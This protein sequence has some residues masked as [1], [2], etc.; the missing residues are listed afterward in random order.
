MGFTVFPEC[1]TSIVVFMKVID[2]YKI[3]VTLN[4]KCDDLGLVQKN[5]PVLVF[6]AE[7]DSG[8]LI[9][10]LVRNFQR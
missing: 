5:Y 7:Y 2:F 6:F 1:E 4:I 10:L 8:E 3:P 9:R